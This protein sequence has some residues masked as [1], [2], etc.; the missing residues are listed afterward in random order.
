MC[1]MGTVQQIELTL[2]SF[3][4]R[5]TVQKLVFCIDNEVTWSS[6]AEVKDPLRPEQ[7]DGLSLL[8][9]H[10]PRHASGRNTCVAEHGM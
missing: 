7:K 5:E 2:V 9:T 3:L 10:T 6:S 8:K 4:D 1:E